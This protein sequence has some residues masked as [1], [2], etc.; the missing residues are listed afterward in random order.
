M[1]YPPSKPGTEADYLAFDA[2]YEYKSEYAKGKIWILSGVSYAHNLI[3]TGTLMGLHMQAQDRTDI[4]LFASRL[5][6][7]VLPTGSFRYPDLMVIKGKSQII[8]DIEQDTIINPTVLIEI[9]DEESYGVDTI[10]KSFEYRRIASLQD[11][12]IIAQNAPHIMHYQRVSTDD[13]KWKIDD[14][15]S[16]DDVIELP[17]IGCTLKLSDIYRR[18]DFDDDET[19]T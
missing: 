14:Y 10:D 9:L 16:L 1:S 12:L 4:E 2:G 15:T 11:Y 3:S 7:K 18:I 19:D 17:A 13:T 8:E 5:R 6:I